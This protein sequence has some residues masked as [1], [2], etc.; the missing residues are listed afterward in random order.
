MSDIILTV[1]EDHTVYVK[2][3]KHIDGG[4]LTECGITEEE[5]L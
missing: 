4:Y 2:R 1:I 5:V 3:E